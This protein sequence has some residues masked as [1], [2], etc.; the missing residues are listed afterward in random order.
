MYIIPGTSHHAHIYT[1]TNSE[2]RLKE[3]SRFLG[4]R[5]LGPDVDF[6]A[7]I[8]PKGHLFPF[9]LSTVL[10]TYTV[11]LSCYLMS[12]SMQMCSISPDGGPLARYPVT[13]FSGGIMTAEGI[14]QQLKSPMNWREISGILRCCSGRENWLR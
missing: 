2:A 7:S 6:G 3:F 13:S 11:A 1:N 9:H 14:S 5:V 10:F 4:D 12:N 8:F